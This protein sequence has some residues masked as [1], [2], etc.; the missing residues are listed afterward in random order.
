MM[1][2]DQVLAMVA[3]SQEFDQIKVRTVW[4]LCPE[5]HRGL[6]SILPLTAYK[7]LK[8]KA[9]LA[10][11][12][13]VW[14]TVLGV[15]CGNQ[16]LMPRVGQNT[17]SCKPV[18]SDIATGTKHLATALSNS[19]KQQQKYFKIGENGSEHIL[20]LEEPKINGSHVST[21]LP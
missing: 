8:L 13:C 15:S 10:C 4:T 19:P 11:Y 9:P 2:E 1:T 7:S 12:H 21:A 3:K 5:A 14:Y 20:V 16:A 18:M 6:S 17:I